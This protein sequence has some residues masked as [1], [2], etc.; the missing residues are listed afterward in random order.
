MNSKEFNHT[1]EEDLLKRNKELELQI[2]ELK[3]TD[4]LTKEY[5]FIMESE[6]AKQ[7]NQIASL[8][9]DVKKKD[10]KIKSLKKDIKKK[11]GKIKSFEKKFKKIQNENDS[12]KSSTS[13]KITSPLRNITNKFRK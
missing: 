7:K 12:L 4:N 3:F 5:L 6:N 9:R 11:D 2:N 8:K 1:N 10:N 13:W